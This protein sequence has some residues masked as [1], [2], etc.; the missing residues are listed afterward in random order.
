MID[1][2]I[3]KQTSVKS[4]KWITKTQAPQVYAQPEVETQPQKP[5]AEIPEFINRLPDLKN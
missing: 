3:H 1:G 5:T 2:E 4:F